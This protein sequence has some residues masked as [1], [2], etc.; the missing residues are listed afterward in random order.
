[1]LFFS[2]GMAR[3]QDLNISGRVVD[4]AGDAVVGASVVVK[5]TTTGVTTGINGDYDISAPSD[6]TLTFSFLGVGSAEEPINGRGRIDIVLDGSGTS[7]DQ[8]IEEVVVVAYGV[9]ARS[10]ASFGAKTTVKSERLEAVS[11]SSFDKALQ[12]Q[13][14]GV[15]SLSNSGQPGA[16]QQVVIRGVSSINGGTT[17]LYVIDGI[18]ILTGNYGNMTQTSSSS[19][20]GD[21]LNALS[22]INPADIE[23]VTVLKDAGSTAIYGSRAANGVVFITTKQ[24]K[25]GK[26]QFNLKLEYGFSNRTQD[27]PKA[28]NQEQYLDYLTDAYTN[29]GTPPPYYDNNNTAL[30]RMPK[31]SNVGGKDVLTLI[32]N[33]FRVRNADGGFYDFDW[34]NHSI[35]ANAPT[36]TADFSAR[37]GTEKTKFYLSLGATSQE[38]IVINTNMKRYTGTLN[39]NHDVNKNV[40]LGVSTKMSYNDQRSPMTTGGYYVN[41]MFGAMMY[42]PLDAGIISNGSTLYTPPSKPGGTETYT[43]LEAG[44]NIDYMTSYASA[45]YLANAAYDDFSSRISRNITNGYAQWSFLDGFTLKGQAGY[46]Y[47]YIT[48]ENWL[49]ARPKGNTASYGHGYA[50]NTSRE[51]Y[52]WSQNVTLNYIKTFKEAHNVNLMLGQETQGEGF[53]YLDATKVDFPGG[54]FHYPSQGATPYAV[55]GEKHASTLASFFGTLNYNYDG[56]Y[57]LSGTLR[58]DGSSRLSV[59]NRW[60]AF[61]SA[62]AQWKLKR[63]KFLENITMLNDLTLSGSYGTSGNQSGISRYAAM[64]LY[65]GVNYNDGSGLFP[66]QIAN[67]EL[68]WERTGTMDIGLTAAAFDSRLRLNLDYYDRLTTGGLLDAQLSRTSGFTSILSNI[69]QVR[70]RGVEAAL[71]ATPY[72]SDNI[73]WTI[74]F[75]ITHNKNKIEKLYKGD[76]IIN[77]PYL[78]REGE[79]IHTLYTYR[80]AGVNPADGRPMYYDDKGEIVYAYNE[81]SANGEQRQIAGSVAPKFY[82][83]LTTT[84][85]AYGFDL[86]LGFF[87]TYGNKIYDPSYLFFTSLGARALWNQY[88]EV[89]TERWRQEGDIARFPKAYYGYS[90]ANYGT[91]TDQII[92]DG[93][94]IRLRDVTLGY[95]IPKKLLNYVKLSS[96][97]LYAKGTNLLTFTKFPDYDPEV[98][99]GRLAGYYYLGYPN[100]RTIVFGL[101]IN[102]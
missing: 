93:S 85:R 71:G 6:G 79:D 53:S 17:P 22:S 78:Y 20:S 14:A 25:A 49:D 8:E 101:D 19:T 60:A 86:T 94:Y 51:V 18:P 59:E 21:N 38:G 9:N 95:S 81:N 75:N 62:G 39:L 7:G 76:D 72:R 5:G 67:P 92:F 32:A 63:E 84:L 37:G 50:N 98:G 69:A 33:N 100:A 41:P 68:T 42:P 55:S 74:D 90:L 12:G 47:F 43:P 89:A 99:G 61:W 57:F 83:G 24:G 56:K 3:A 54:Y 102:F 46:D 87:Y 27:R 44:P 16:G 31:Y 36:Y 52:S 34:M 35:I 97:R 64:S 82:G 80:W 48:E 96:V 10:G 40:K 4:A 91:A 58:S 11:V 45:N 26:T 65:G 77:A 66:T 13:V 70:N 1:M 23:S 29:A 15:L 88:S 30:G 73:T 28:M 2:A